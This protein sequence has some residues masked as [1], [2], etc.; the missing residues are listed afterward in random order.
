MKKVSP[1]LVIAALATSARACIEAHVYFQGS[2]LTN[3]LMTMQVWVNQQLVCSYTDGIYQ[4]SDDS[5]FCARN[6]DGEGE[7]CADGYTFCVH[8]YG[9][10]AVFSYYGTSIAHFL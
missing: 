4:S 1:F 6:S 10:T 5:V 2:F 3:D 8:D 7:G 9:E